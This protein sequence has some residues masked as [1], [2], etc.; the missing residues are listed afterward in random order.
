ASSAVAATVSGRASNQATGDLLNGAEVRVEGTNI[1][2]AT[3]RGG[4]YRLELPEGTHTLVVSY[5]GLDTE[6]IPISVG[7]ENIVKDV[8]LTTGIYKLEAFSV[9]G[10][11]EGNA[12]AIQQQRLADNPKWV[13][14]V[15]TFGNPAANPG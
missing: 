4:S 15:D 7:A 10:V 6:H 12:L 1:V 5:A 11:R 8:E 9:A 3:E 14:A 2:T 13:A